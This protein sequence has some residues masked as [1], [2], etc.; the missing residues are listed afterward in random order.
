MTAD[1]LWQDNGGYISPANYNDVMIDGQLNVMSDAHFN[2][3]MTHVNSYMTD[4]MGDVALNGFMTM[5]NS[6][7]LDVW[8]DANFYGNVQRLSPETM[9]K[10]LT[11]KGYVDLGDATNAAAIASLSD[12][13]SS[14]DSTMTADALWQEDGF[15]N[16]TNMNNMGVVMQGSLPWSGFRFNE[17]GN[18]ETQIGDG[19]FGLNIN[20]YGDMIDLRG[21][22]IDIDDGIG[23]VHVEFG[24]TNI[25]DGFMGLNVSWMGDDI[26]INTMQFDINAPMGTNFNNDVNIV[27]NLTAPTIAS[28]SDERFKK[29]IK[30]I[31]NALEKVLS[32]RGVNYYWNQKDFIDRK[33]DNKLEIGL[34]AQEV[35]KIIPEVVHDGA[36][37]YKSIEYSKLVG[38]L[39]E[40][41][42][43]QQKVIADQKDELAEIRTDFDSRLQELE[44]ILKTTT[45]KN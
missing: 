6:A 38:L 34:I 27:G 40:A 9:S 15:G 20:E 13:I 2:G 36:D 10:D 22:M 16:I 33:F 26:D 35:E 8:S 11:S 7:I 41:I 4:F 29:E 19:F 31:D 37:G 18:G 23:G 32:L 25:G 21:M 44:S 17:N 45:L 42:K 12:S 43:E 24:E 1:A 28:S 5:I 3:F 30:T 14:L 39:I